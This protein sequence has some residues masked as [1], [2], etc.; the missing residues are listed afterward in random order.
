MPIPYQPLQ[1]QYSGPHA[2][3]KKVSKVDYVIDTPDWRK[4]WRMCHVNML[5][6]YQQCSEETPNTT[7]HPEILSQ[8]LCS[9]VLKDNSSS[10]SADLVVKGSPRLK[11]SDILK[12]FQAEKLSYLEAVK[13]EEIMQLVFQFVNL[14]PDTPSQ[15]DQVVHDVDVGEATPIKQHPYRVNPLKLKIIREEVAYM[16]DND[17]IKISNSEW[18]SPRVLVTKPDGM[19]HFCIDFR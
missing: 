4:S 17:R 12:K 9:S 2:I 14:F 7:N 13:Q 1:A 6:S 5:K 15:T 8:V 10:T 16:L 18:S 11:N 3:T 19:Y